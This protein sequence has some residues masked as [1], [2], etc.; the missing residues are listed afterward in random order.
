MERQASIK[1][2]HSIDAVRYEGFND[3]ILEEFERI[4]QGF[5]KLPLI[6]TMKAFYTD[7][8]A[9]LE[10]KNPHDLNIRIWASTLIDELY[11]AY[12]RSGHQGTVSDMMSAIVKLIEVGSE[13][14]VKA[15][16][17]TEKAINVSG[18]RAL[19]QMHQ[20][21][22][23][24]HEEIFNRIQPGPFL[25]STPCIAFNTL[26]SE[27]FDPF[28]ND[29][30][31]L[32]CW[33]EHEGTL[34]FEI[35]HDTS[36]LEEENTRLLAFK[37]SFV[38]YALEFQYGFPEGNLIGYLSGTHHL[39]AEGDKF[40]I[41]L[42]NLE[43]GIDRFVLFYKENHYFIRSQTASVEIEPTIFEHPPVSFSMGMPLQAHGNAIHNF[44]YYAACASAKQQVQ[45][46]A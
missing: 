21:D 32:D 35:I 16:Y 34:F 14:D 37:L 10:H 25:L 24:A 2:F 1:G 4:I 39:L 36:L 31:T 6:E 11:K 38:D 40:T 5:Y 28:I 7:L 12:L 20:E 19:F 13:I 45:L 3:R 18:W 23:Y 33:N 17:S 46:L 44:T 27:N 9:H 22:R 30:Y 41:P 8:T 43:K 42:L 15:G 26:F 29:G